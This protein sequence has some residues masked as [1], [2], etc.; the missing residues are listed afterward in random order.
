MSKRQHN[1]T[2]IDHVQ[3]DVG[4]EIAVSLFDDRKYSVP[5]AAKKFGI[6]ANKMRSIIKKGFIRVLN[7]D[8]QLMLP[9]SG[10]I[11]YLESNYR[12][13]QEAI[14]RPSTAL[15]ALPDRIKN[16]PYLKRAGQN[17]A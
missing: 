17:A 16:S 12:T 14:V 7:L 8:G 1:T 9:E 2:E 11:R 3:E 5:A 15:P 10:L 13:I 4:C 6:S